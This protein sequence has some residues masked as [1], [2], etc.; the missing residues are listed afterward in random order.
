MTGCQAKVYDQIVDSNR[1]DSLD[2][3]PSLFV[4]FGRVDRIHEFIEHLWHLRRLRHAP[5]MKGGA[6]NPCSFFVFPA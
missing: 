1:L 5:P 6:T 3:N 4:E 2:V